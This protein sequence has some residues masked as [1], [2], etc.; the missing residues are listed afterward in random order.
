[1]SAMLGS[2]RKFAHIV[3]ALTMIVTVVTVAPQTVLS[4]Q[5]QGPFNSYKAVS[6]GYLHSCGITGTDVVRCWGSEEKI[7]VGLG[8]VSHIS[9]GYYATCVIKKPSAEA[10]CW[11]D[12]DVEQYTSVPPSLGKVLEIS[13]GF[14]HACAVT[15][16]HEAKCWGNFQRGYAA[17]PS[18]LG[19]IDHIS[20]GTLLTC[21]ITVEGDP[22]CWGYNSNVLTGAGKVKQISVGEDNHVC[23]ISLTDTLECWSGEAYQNKIAIPEGIGNVSQVESGDNFTCVLRLNEVK[24]DCWGLY[25]LEDSSPVLNFQPVA[26]SAW[27]DHA[28]AISASGSVQCWGDNWA[29]QSTPP[30]GIPLPNPPQFTFISDSLGSLKVWLNH[31]YDSSQGSLK[32]YVFE[33]ER[34]VC[35]I[36]LSG[37]CVVDLVPTRNYTFTVI[38]VNEAGE[39][40]PIS[41]SVKFCPT[42]DPAI[43]ISGNYLTKTNKKVTFKGSTTVYNLCDPAPKTIEYR[44]KVYGKSWTAWKSFKLSGSGGFNFSDTFEFNSKVELR[45]K[46]QGAKYS[47]KDIAIPVAINYALPLSFYPKAN[48]IKSG[49]TQGGEIT[50]KFGG[51]KAFN[52]TCMVVAKTDYAF[53]FALVSVGKESTFTIFKVKNGSGSGK[54]TMRWNGKVNVSALCEDPK[55]VD[56]FD[57]RTPTFRTNF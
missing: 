2:L 36:N 49:Y 1:M 52:G 30:A 37:Y 20:V 24:V 47:T 15:I 57:Y 8:P 31:Q 55:F 48:K 51:D 22:K 17:I 33:G 5:A 18:D 32:W 50:V 38:G 12:S 19:K 42:Q 25:N 53:N 4:A 43:N 27:N 56:I 13:T 11:S 41:K 16:E 35:L 45:A 14:W 46:L 10:A 26:V 44:K 40:Q 6:A 7:P 54:V 28:C 29:G 34:V 3:I 9:A 23:T 39:T 21:A